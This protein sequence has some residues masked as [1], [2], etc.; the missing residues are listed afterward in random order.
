MFTLF[1]VAFLIGAAM[2]PIALF[3]ALCVMLLVSATAGPWCTVKAFSIILSALFG[4]ALIGLCA[5]ECE[6]KIPKI[7]RSKFLPETKEL[8]EKRA[9]R[10]EK[11]ADIIHNLWLVWWSKEIR[12]VFVTLATL[13][14]VVAYTQMRSYFPPALVGQIR[15]GSIVSIVLIVVIH[16]FSPAQKAAKQMEDIQ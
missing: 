16:L 7:D 14:M 6:L 13:T 15:L 1:Q 10:F 11:V 5:I 8:A 9:D 4:P 12:I 3:V 2:F